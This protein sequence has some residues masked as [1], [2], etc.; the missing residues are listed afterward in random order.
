MN[1]CRRPNIRYHFFGFIPLTIQ[2]GVGWAGME[3]IYSMHQAAVFW[4]RV[5][6]EEL[7]VDEARAASSAL[8]VTDMPCREYRM[9][10]ACRQ[11]LS[12]PPL[13]VEGAPPKTCTSPR[14]WGGCCLRHQ[15]CH[16]Y[17]A[18]HGIPLIAGASRS[19][20]ATLQQRSRPQM[21][22]V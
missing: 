13:N 8:M 14:A 10:I 6:A 5:W 17:P 11:S 16:R 15:G 3:P 12:A 9:D 19:Q 4:H 22:A 2:E 7:G 21:D 18:H 20:L 1:Y